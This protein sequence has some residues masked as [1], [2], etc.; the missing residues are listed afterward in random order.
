MLNVF[1]IYSLLIL[2]L[3]N[4]SNCY[5]YNKNL[6]N[7]MNGLFMKKETTTSKLSFLYSPKTENQ[8]TYYNYLA[9]KNSS[10]VIATGPAGTGKTLLACSSAIQQL[11]NNEIEKIILTRPVVSVEEE[12]GFLPGNLAQKMDPWTRPIFDIFNEYYLMSEVTNMIKNGVIEISP[13]GFM[14]GRT[15]KKSCIIADEMQNSSPNQMFMLLTR[16]GDKSKMVITGDLAQSDRQVNNG[17][18]DLIMKYKKNENNIE[19]IHLVELNN[20][21]IKR[22]KLVET[23][24][25]MYDTQV[26]DI[27]KESFK[28]GFS[29]AALMPKNHYKKL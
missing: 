3:L 21:D 17:L 28:N 5:L 7:K 10:I 29:D 1:S 9:S 12:I 2:S 8:R 24:I 6:V 13:L 22:S 23:V 16:I 14:R 25:Q 4:N 20:A 15:F 18:K 11:K 19:N 26:Q 27:N